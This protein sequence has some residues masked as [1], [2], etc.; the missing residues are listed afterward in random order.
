MAM[1]AVCADGSANESAPSDSSSDSEPLYASAV[2]G[3][4]S[5]TPQC[6][7]CAGEEG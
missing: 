1:A 2:A 6:R 5:N 4:F 3:T 7:S